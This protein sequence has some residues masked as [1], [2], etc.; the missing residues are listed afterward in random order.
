[1]PTL[2]SSVTWSWLSNQ[3]PEKRPFF[4]K[5]L[6]VRLWPK[7]RWLSKA[8]IWTQHPG[9][10]LRL[11]KSYFWDAQ[12]HDRNLRG[13][14]STKS[15]NFEQA[16]LGKYWHWSKQFVVFLSI[17]MQKATSVSFAALFMCDLSI[18]MMS[19]YAENLG[20]KC[21]TDIFFIVSVNV[22]YE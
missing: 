12:S 13:R 11:Y 8:E 1:M 22:A 18:F 6:L 3:N 15:G 17:C 19:K 2:G 5:D 14:E 21:L 9:C 7:K 10:R 20:N 4:I 16:Y